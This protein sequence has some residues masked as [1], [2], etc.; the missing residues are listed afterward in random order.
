MPPPTTIDEI[1]AALTARGWSALARRLAYFASAEDLEPG[2]GCEFAG[3]AV[4]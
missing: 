2:D 4:T 3:A 1:C